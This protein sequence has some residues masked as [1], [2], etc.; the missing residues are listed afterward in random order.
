MNLQSSH[1]AFNPLLAWQEM[2]NYI[3]HFL[4]EYPNLDP[5]VKS[6]IQHFQYQ[7]LLKV[8]NI[9]PQ[10][11]AN[12]EQNISPWS[13]RCRGDYHRFY[14][15]NPLLNAVEEALSIQKENAQVF[16]LSDRKS[17]EAH[18]KVASCLNPEVSRLYGQCR[19]ISLK[20]QDVLL[21]P[22]S[23]K[24]PI[25]EFIVENGF[26]PTL[27]QAAGAACSVMLTQ[28]NLTHEFPKQ[29]NRE[30]SFASFLKNPV[31]LKFQHLGLK[32]FSAGVLVSLF[33]EFRKIELDIRFSQKGVHSLLSD[34]YGRVLW[35]LKEALHL[36]LSQYGSFPR[37]ESLLDLA[38]EEILLWLLI[39]EPYSESDLRE[40]IENAIVPP[41]EPNNLKNRFFKATT[42]SENFSLPSCPGLE[43]LVPDMDSEE[44][45]Y[46]IPDSS[47]CSGRFLKTVS[48]GMAAFS[49]ILRVLLLPNQS[50]LLFDGC[51]FENRASL[52]KT[53]PS[54][55]FYL[56]RFPDYNAS[57]RANLDLLK[58]QNKTLDLVFI[59]FHENILRGR[60]RSYENRV[61]DVLAQIFQEKRAA[62][63][64]TVV[65]DHTIGF[66]NS[67]EV[68]DLLERFQAEIE[69]RMLHFVILWSHQKF[70]LFG[71]DKVSAGSYA[72]YSQ[73]AALMHR[74]QT[75]SSGGID[76]ITR[77]CLAHYFKTASQKLEERR[78][79]IFSNAFYVNS[80]IAEPLKYNGENGA[81]PIL[82]VAKEDKEN[83]SIDVQC[84]LD[85]ELSICNAFLK[86]GIPLMLR[87][88]FGYNLTTIAST[89]FHTLRFSIG[90]EEHKF[91][92]Q[93]LEA[94][95]DIFLGELERLTK[96]SVFIDKQR[97]VLQ[98]L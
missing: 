45:S 60:Y 96:K 30:P 11:A 13:S 79:R 6:R 38:H 41:V 3:S 65:I 32:V 17:F 7:Y 20:G 85:L 55:N 10:D 12:F 66:L 75:I 48:T 14:H 69:A 63:T 16:L 98:D 59:N 80:K 76:S 62:P 70:D 2:D 78:A 8:S 33:E 88:G 72:V 61:G 40:L 36:D 47:T 67:Q 15:L 94:F 4:I 24:E 43:S 23:E 5:H 29:M 68:R 9:C 22:E 25:R 35:F 18:L 86:R 28:E 82:V 58:S 91:L 90:I 92:D 21:V 84:A 77:Q 49:E 46:Q 51:Y 42:F 71:F 83:F 19:F 54:K 39:S 73:D 97:I 93:F 37:F 89:R 34:S 74:F 50:I 95:N 53:Y 27:Q 52:L 81:Q 26:T 31:Y 87:S 1:A 56:V 57:F 64:L 44:S